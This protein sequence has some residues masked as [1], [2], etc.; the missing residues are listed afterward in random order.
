MNALDE[1]RPPETGVLV[2][3]DDLPETATPSCAVAHAIEDTCGVSIRE[4][5]N[6]IDHAVNRDALDVLFC[7]RN[8]GGKRVGGSL[9]FVCPRLDVT[10]TV[11]ACG[12]LRIDPVEA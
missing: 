6:E 7:D 11:F 8:D 10:V 1:Y 4:A 5:T 2:P 3:A 9:S 12:S